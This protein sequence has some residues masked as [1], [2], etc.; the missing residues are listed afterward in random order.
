MMIS[1]TIKID[2]M[3][4]QFI[5]YESYFSELFAVSHKAKCLSKGLGRSTEPLNNPDLQKSHVLCILPFLFHWSFS[6]CCLL[7][8]LIFWKIL[9]T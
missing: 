3:Y 1:D 5:N 9:G 4:S 8:F 2:F 6:L 7:H